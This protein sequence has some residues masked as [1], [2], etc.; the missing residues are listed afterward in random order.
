MMSSTWPA[1]DDRLTV[2]P[3]SSAKEKPLV[4]SELVLLHEMFCAWAPPTSAASV[5]AA[6]AAAAEWERIWCG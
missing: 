6:A 1:Y 4:Y 3:F 2:V 5:T